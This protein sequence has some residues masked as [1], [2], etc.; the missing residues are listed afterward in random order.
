MLPPPH[1][2]MVWGVGGLHTDAERCGAERE[3]ARASV[4]KA[5]TVR[6]AVRY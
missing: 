1:A 2:G 4:T 5:L 3:R 6:G